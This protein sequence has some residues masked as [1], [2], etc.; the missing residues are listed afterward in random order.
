MLENLARSLGEHVWLLVS[1]GLVLGLVVGSFLNVVIVRLPKIM[2]RQWKAECALLLEAPDKAPDSSRPFDLVR[3]ASHCP[4]CGRGI[5]AWENIPLLSFVL[6]RGRCSGCGMR[7][8]LRYPLVEALTAAL[9]A[10]TLWHFGASLFGLLVLLMVWALIAMSFIDLDTQLLPDSLTLPVLWLGLLASLHPESLVG[11]KAAIVGAAAGYLSLWLV[12]HLFRLLTGKEGMGY[13]D[14]KLMAL[15]GAWMG[16]I[17]L[18]LVIILG[19]GLGVLAAIVMA[20]GGRKVAG[21]PMPFGP[22]LAGAGLVA[23][24]A[25]EPIIQTY[26]RLSG[27]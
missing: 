1:S 3:P 8:P 20:L 27:L 17:A 7:I 16:W 18:P 19:S 12:Y 13:G 21:T 10:L 26:L 5:R 2:E 24:F 9:S 11:P 23:L 25:G 6:L 4:G 22:F 14:F 15:L